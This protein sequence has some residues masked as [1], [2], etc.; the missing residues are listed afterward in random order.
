MPTSDP[1]D[2]MNEIYQSALALG[3]AS[4]ISMILQKFTKMSL[5]TPMSLKPFVMLAVSLGIRQCV[6]KILEEKNKKFQPSRLKLRN[7]LA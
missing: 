5:G 4:G 1:K 6:L 2:L 7:A 3:I